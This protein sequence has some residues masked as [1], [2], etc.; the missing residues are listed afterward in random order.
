[1]CPPDMRVSFVNRYVNPVVRAIL[2]SPAHPLLSSHLMLLTVTAR[3]SGREFT[4]P[5]GYTR[6]GDRLVV[7]LQWPE[8]KRWWRNLEGGAPV[9]VV[10][11]GVRR[12][13]TGRVTRDAG[14]VP[15]V[16]IELDAGAA[17]S[18]ARRAAAARRPGARTC[19]RRRGR[20][21]GWPP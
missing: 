1:M 12:T 10:V 13:G 15:G 4:I 18:R 5:V 17:V 2:R 8:R 6:H 3:R 14:G 7:S 9:A 21:S 16:V 11:R 19:G 20:R